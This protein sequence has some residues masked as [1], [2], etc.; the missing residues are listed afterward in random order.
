LSRHKQP[1]FVE[2]PKVV[3]VPKWTGDNVIAGTNPLS[4][5]F[6]HR[7][8]GGPFGW[9]E[10]SSEKL[11]GVIARFA[12]LEGMTWEQIKATGSHPIECAR[13]CEAARARL[14]AIGHDDLDE[15]MS[16]RVMGAVRVWC[17]H[18]TSIMRV[19]WWDP[20]HEVYP[21]PVDKADRKKH[22]GK[23]K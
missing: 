8:T 15:M 3:K 18:D 4:W 1:K 10:T 11:A 22:S 19:L 6:S 13:L 2:K 17:I 5:R 21:T 14:V 23:A 20:K 7:D 16:F 12:E 9:Q